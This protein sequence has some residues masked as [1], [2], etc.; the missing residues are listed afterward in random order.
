MNFTNFPIAPPSAS[1]FAPQI[2]GLYYFLWIF[3]AIFTLIVGFFVVF[4]SI[5]YKEGSP[6]DRSRPLYEHIGLELTWSV[7]PGILGLVFFYLGA[8]LFIHMRTPPKDAKEIFVVGKQWMWHIQHP[9]GVRENNTLHVPIDTPIKLTMISQD[10][11]HAFFV[12]AF[13]T[14]MMVVPGRYTDLWFTPTKIGEYH[15]FCNMYCG[16]QHSEMGGT[17]VVMPQ[18][19]YSEWLKNN[20]M[21]VAN[22]TMEQRGAKIFSSIGCDKCH[23]A[24]DTIHGPTLNGLYGS[25]RIFTD[26]SSAMANDEYIRESILKPHSRLTK[27]YGET[28]P[29]YANDLTE[30]QVLLL[31]TFIRTQGAIPAGTA[32][33]TSNLTGA[34]IPSSGAKTNK[35]TAMSVNADQHGATPSTA[36]PTIQKGKLSVGATAANEKNQ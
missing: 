32:G 25:K 20:G 10:V 27:G 35:N 2:D 9:N 4:F 15:L 36:T 11:I 26:G 34:E 24:E 21:A 22:L 12:P 23:T 14:Q 13:R 8:R 29:E 31:N 19:D 1:T 30:E 18:A 28:M 7:I 5:H 16:T 33:T 17:V 6:A 3:T